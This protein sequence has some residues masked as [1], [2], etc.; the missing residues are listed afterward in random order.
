LAS[1]RRLRQSSKTGDRGWKHPA[2][3][4]TAQ[5]IAGESHSFYIPAEWVAFP[6]AMFI[7]NFIRAWNSAKLQQVP[8]FVDHPLYTSNTH[9]GVKQARRDGLKSFFMS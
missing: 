3:A 7:Y 6:R 2:G 1:D 9:L 5:A 8:N 4:E